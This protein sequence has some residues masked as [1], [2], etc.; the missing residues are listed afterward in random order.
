M[1]S[2]VQKFQFHMF[3]WV[4]LDMANQIKFVNVCKSCNKCIFLQRFKQRR[5]LTDNTHTF[6]VLKTNISRIRKGVTG[7]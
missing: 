2:L 4:C 1:V 5:V 3:P 7:N 6:R